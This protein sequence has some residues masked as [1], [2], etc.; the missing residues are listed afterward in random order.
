MRAVVIEQFGGKDQLKMAEM[1]VPIPQGSE[2]LIRIKYASVNPVD[3]KIREGMLKDAIPH[4]FPVILGRDAAGVV[5]AMGT[6]VKRFHVGDKV[7]AFGRKPEIHDGT[8]AEY[9]TLDE[10][11]VAH[12]PKNL[13]FREA[14]AVPLAGLTAW[15]ALFSMAELREGETVLILGGAGG[16]G[17]FAVQF[18]KTRGV[19][20]IFAT[21][22]EEHH[23]YLL[24]IGADFAIDYTKQDVAKAVKQQVPEGVDVVCDLVGGEALHQSFSLI[25]PGGRLVSTVQEPDQ[26]LIAAHDVKAEAMLTEPNGEQ[27]AQIT[28]LIETNRVKPPVI[29]EFDLSDA[30]AAQSQSQSHHVEGKLVLKVG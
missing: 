19:W 7:Y 1:P 29:H 13:S 25:K 11:H 23:S 20:R 4:R 12:M 22:R 24:S 8:Y 16:V 26:Q 2:V 3:W 9:I 21:A 27:L 30:A 15:Q 10:S 5:E 28:K 14:A 17:S 18:A 6:H